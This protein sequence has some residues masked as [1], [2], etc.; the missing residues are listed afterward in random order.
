MTKTGGLPRQ[1]R[2]TPPVRCVLGLFHG[3]DYRYERRNEVL[4]I[5]VA[6]KSMCINERITA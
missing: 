1:I 6:H 2:V 3:D 5:S 4:R